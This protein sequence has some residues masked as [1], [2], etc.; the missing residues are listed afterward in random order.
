M[1]GSCRQRLLLLSFRWLFPSEVSL[2]SLQ[3]CW[4]TRT[5]IPLAWSR[6]LRM[7]RSGGGIIPAL[8]RGCGVDKAARSARRRRCALD[9]GCLY[10]LYVDRDIPHQ[11]HPLDNI[12]SSLDYFFPACR[13]RPGNGGSLEDAGRMVRA[14]Y[15]PR[16]TLPLLCRSNE[17][18]FRTESDSGRRTY[19][20]V[21]TA[22][23]SRQ[24]HR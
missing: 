6:S 8:D 23:F 22:L 24:D 15:R 13:S 11:L 14:G 16:R 18:N 7:V 3:A 17:R 4:N 1:R 5:A 20:E 21:I 9:V 12:P 19:P 10:T 2:R